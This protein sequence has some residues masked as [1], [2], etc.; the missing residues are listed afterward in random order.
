LSDA[1][2]PY[3]FVPLTETT[4]ESARPDDLDRS[5][6]VKGLKS[7][8]IDITVTTET[9]LYIRAAVPRKLLPDRSEKA[10]SVNELSW[11][12]YKGKIRG[13]Q[14]FFHHGNPDRPVI[15]GSELR[16]VIRNLLTIMSGSALRRGVN[17]ER[18]SFPLYRDVAGPTRRARDYRAR[19]AE[20]HVHGG[21]LYEKDGDWYI[22]PAKMVNGMDFVTVAADRVSLK[23]PSRTKVWVRPPTQ[24]GREVGG[25]RRA[26]EFSPEEPEDGEGWEPA[27]LI[28]TAAV[29]RPKRWHCAVLEP[30]EGGTRIPVPPEVR[31]RFESDQ[32][33][34]RSQRGLD[35]KPERQACFYTAAEGKVTAFGP[36]RNF[37]IPTRYTPVDLQPMTP[38][39]DFVTG[40][41]G[42][43]D[44]HVG[45]VAF[46]DLTMT[47]A[48]E[49]FPGIRKF[50]NALFYCT[51]SH[52]LLAP[53]PQAPQMY[54]TRL[55][56]QGLATYDDDPKQTRIRGHKLYWHSD[57]AASNLEAI[58]DNP[59]D[60]TKKLF[61]VIRPVRERVEFAGRIHFDQ[62]YGAELGGLLAALLLPRSK[63]HKIGLG[64][65][66]GLGS[67]RIEVEGVHLIDTGARYSKFFNEEVLTTGASVPV[68]TDLYP[69]MFYRD[70]CGVAG[71]GE[72]WSQR[73]MI[74]LAALL[75]WK[76]QPKSDS[77]RYVEKGGQQ[78]Q[79]RWLLPGPTQV[80]QG[81]AGPGHG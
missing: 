8:W 33:I 11:K 3:N 18:T 35:L 15:P 53:K 52:P 39:D 29:G 80:L 75:E 77:V 70:V 78:W 63:R 19:A 12:H 36:T 72:F 31:R 32:Q 9:P 7:G 27:W 64:R 69:T 25:A 67:A 65:P 60:D 50:K 49:G 13:Y 10:S 42:R 43:L 51:T 26:A 62:L 17:D 58:P 1:V 71:K 16:G 14:E 47:C 73:R 38:A 76:H 41:F 6:F 45:R 54:L 2:A 46:E 81:P 20:E 28:V 61:S 48:G 30:P 79:Q 5:R 74:D 37:R 56:G 24:I 34:K 21:F 40:M 66:L 44:G 57:A 68:R 59:D 4:S 55:K 22:R 23:P